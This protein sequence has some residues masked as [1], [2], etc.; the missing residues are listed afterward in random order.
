MALHLPKSLLEKQKPR[1]DRGLL[2]QH[3]FCCPHMENGSNCD[4]NEPPLGV[5]GFTLCKGGSDLALLLLPAAQY[6]YQNH[7]ED[8]FHADKQSYFC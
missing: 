8:N 1:Q 7:R 6:A 4:T 2:G 3:L 5:R